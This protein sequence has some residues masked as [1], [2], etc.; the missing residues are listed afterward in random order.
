MIALTN[1]VA[2]FISVTSYQLWLSLPS[3]STA[4]APVKTLSTR[5]APAEPLPHLIPKRLPFFGGHVLEVCSHLVHSRPH[6]RYLFF[7]HSAKAAAFRTRPDHLNHRRPRSLGL[8]APFAP[9][10]TRR[11]T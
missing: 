9:F 1:A 10:P 5:P 8:A 6:F 11:R 3:A 4:A 2:F 7:R